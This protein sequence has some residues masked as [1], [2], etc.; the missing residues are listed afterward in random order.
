MKH[1]IITSL[2]ILS[3]LVVRADERL[4]LVQVED[5]NHLYT[6]FENQDLTIHYYSD[7]FIIATLA[8]GKTVAQSVVLDEA[9]FSD[10]HGYFI[11]YCSPS[12]RQSYLTDVQHEGKLLYA[13][14]NILIM[15]PLAR[16]QQ[17]RPAKN[18]GIV[19]ISQDRAYLPQTKFVFPV[20]DDID[21]MIQYLTEMVDTENF[22]SYVQHLEDYKT[23]VYYTPQAFQA[24]DWLKGEFE[25]MGL[26]V[27]IQPLTYPSSSSGNVIAIQKGKVYEDEYIVCGAHYDSYTY[28]IDNAPG[29]DD[30]A[31]GTATVL[32]MARILSQYE[33]ERSIVY[34]AFAA[35]EVGL[36]G[37]KAYAARCK[38]QGMNIL[39][40]FNID[41]TGY[42]K[43]GSPIHI[44]LIYPST[45]N[46]LAEYN[47][48]ITDIYFPDIPI[49]SYS[50]LAGGDSD[51][52]SFNNAGFQGIWTF[53]D[54]ADHSPYIHTTSDKI[55][56]SVNR[57][58]QCRV[59]TQVNLA[60]IA[61]LAGIDYDPA[62][63]YPNFT[64]SDTI[65][66]E[67]SEV[68]FSDLSIN[69]PTE[70]KW[71]FDGVE[72]G[73]SIEQHPKVVYDT[74]GSYD[75]K[76]V[77]TNA[78]GSNELIRKKYI[79]VT[80]TPPIAN[81]EA[82][83][84]EIKE[85]EYVT[86]IH[87]AIQN[88][89]SFSWFFEGGTPMQSTSET[90]PAI[91]YDKAGSYAVRLKVANAGGESTEQ[92]NNYI[93]VTPKDVGIVEQ[94]LASVR[95]YPNPT[96]GV[97]QVTSYELQVTSVEIFDAMGRQVTL[98]SPPE[99][100][101]LPSFGGGGGGNISHLPN[102]IYFVR[103]QTDEGVVVR[104]VV[105]MSEL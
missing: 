18:D 101:R 59:F 42:L 12:Q 7:A 49:I 88:P 22:M 39:G 75:V 74:P 13:N 62:L 9:A 31:T 98:L 8:E 79:T 70:W 37:S 3:S 55:G 80:M 77:V 58:D 24:Q 56:P 82:D 21:P 32:E 99:G 17:L 71:H 67:G 25:T 36:Y 54:W 47:N 72:T 78:F 45:A 65:I 14:D 20:V 87:S 41:M 11:V 96:D 38:Q 27:E 97:I 105:K 34:C 30:N 53:E 61:T 103:I 19:F 68:Q 66:V 6:L 94:G 92:K 48:N 43:P 35:E 93:T 86:F 40:Y 52:T 64:A 29:A 16:S 95:V 15:K 85:G 83:V 46:E 33:T 10:T 44:S 91:R 26:S 84:T 102:G 63:P 5:Q 73:E 50:G 76:L 1:I 69:D 4:V 51:H 100:G 89:Q 2:L 23:R 90:P 60:A 57:P 104:K 81:F 28:N